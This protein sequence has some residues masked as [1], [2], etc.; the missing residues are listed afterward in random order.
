MTNEKSLRYLEGIKSRN[1]AVLTEIYQDI[2]PGITRWVKE[3]GGNDDDAKDLFQEMIISVYKK[4]QAGDFKLTCTFWSYALIVCKNL[5][6]AKNRN[7]DKMKFTD[8]VE[9]EKVL[10]EKDMQEELE[11]K[12]QYVMYRRHFQKLGENCQKILSLFFAKIKMSEIAERLELSP[13]YVKKA[14]FKCKETLTKNIKE[15]AI[16]KELSEKYG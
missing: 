11:K 14:K 5:W 1:S 10:I 7:K 15:D 13:A 9:G 2:L 6:Y 3:N 12:E 8:N 4:S 16:Y